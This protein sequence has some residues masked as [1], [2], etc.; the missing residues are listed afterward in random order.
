MNF[1]RLLQSCA[2][3][4]LFNHIKKDATNIY[5]FHSLL[6]FLYF[7]TFYKFTPSKVQQNSSGYTHSWQLKY[8]THKV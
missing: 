3:L 6:F 5:K 2:L 1:L 8:I 7:H 4:Y